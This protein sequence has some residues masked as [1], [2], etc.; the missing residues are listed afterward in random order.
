MKFKSKYYIQDWSGN[1]KTDYYGEFKTAD[2]AF[3]ALYKEF[4]DLEGKELDE[5]LGEFLVLKRGAK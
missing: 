4:K 3:E 5:T 1:D 2:D